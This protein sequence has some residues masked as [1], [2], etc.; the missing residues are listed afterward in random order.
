MLLFIHS[1]G[2]DPDYVEMAKE[3]GR[4]MLKRNYGLV[5]GGGSYGLMG[6]IAQTI[7]EGGGKVIGVIPEALKNIERPEISE[8]VNNEQIFGEE[9]VVKD[10]HTRKA[11]MNKLT[12]AFITL[13]GGYGT[14]EEL[15]EVTTWSQLSI[16]K[17]PVMLFNMKGYFEHLLKF[18]EHSIEEKFV[19]E[20]S[21]NVIV[22]G[23]T[24]K[25]VL[26]KLE[27]YEP[28]NSRFSLKWDDAD[29]QTKQDFVYKYDVTMTCTGCS[30]AVTRVLSKL[31]G[32]NKFDVSLE[33]QKVT[34]ESETL[35]EQEI[36]E[37]IQKTGKAAKD[38]VKA[39]AEWTQ[40]QVKAREEFN[41]RVYGSKKE[42]G[43]E[44]VTE[45]KIPPVYVVFLGHSMGGLVA[46]DTALLLN[47]LPQKSPVIGILAFDTPYY[48]LN[49]TIFTQAAYERATGFAQKATGAYSLVSAY[50]PAAAA[51]N[52]LSPS[53]VETS[54]DKEKNRDMQTPAPAA[55]SG[56]SPSSLWSATS[57]KSVEKEKVVAT[58]SSSSSSKWGWGTIALGVG[59]AV[60]ATG[61]AVVVNR[62][63]NKGME[64]VTSHLQ[65]VGIL[66]NNA[67]LRRR[68]AN[69]LELPIGFHCFYT[70]VQIPTSS[71][72]NW[73]ST[74]RTFVEL[75]SIPDDIRSKHFSIRECSGQDEIE[76]HMEMFNPGKNFDYYQMGDDSLNRVKTMVEE[77][78][79]R[80][81]LK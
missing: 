3:L 52:T 75:T 42:E 26:D 13:P 16:H 24:A 62:H 68:V 30:G 39:F 61:A 11:L 60:V 49:H 7:H 81:Q 21:K 74:S 69:T 41:K 4:E 77:T 48:G 22:A 44:K 71:S 80:E 38:A 17:K 67:Q 2:R 70:Q 43:D 76:A 6:A 8:S 55:S 53:G 78:L 32:V 50:V 14:M 19:V 37:K 18:I 33:N 79:K 51:W 63:L 59:A 25:E 64:Y 45:D 72:N 57:S 66:W 15:L 1:S 36:L 10:M 5:Y 54:G 40:Q 29:A 23:S 73:K 12:S 56:F 28:P 31:E 65:F 58:K 47:D 34:V 9:I 46:A 35:S 27:A 20:W